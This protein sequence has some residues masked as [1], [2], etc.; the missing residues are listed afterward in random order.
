MEDQIEISTSDAPEWSIETIASDHF[1][2]NPEVADKLV[3][4]WET[5]ITSGRDKQLAG[6]FDRLLDGAMVSRPSVPGKRFEGRALVIVGESGAGKSH[7]IRYLFEKRPSL[8]QYDSEMGKMMP[9]VSVIAP[10]PC[11]L[12]QLA[13]E[14]LDAVGYPTNRNIQENV[15]WRIVKQQLK[16]RRCLILHVDE[17]QH[18]VHFSNPAEQQKLADTLKNLM[19]NPE[20]P[21]RLVLSGLP[22]LTQFRQS[23][24]QLPLRSRIH[25]VNPLQLPADG[26][27]VR[28][29]TKGILE[30]RLGFDISDLEQDEFYQRLCH[31][32]SNF[33]GR[34]GRYLQGGAE[35][36]IYAREERATREHFGEAYFQITGCTPEQNIFLAPNWHQIDPVEALSEDDEEDEPKGKTGRKKRSRK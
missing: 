17:A 22:E 26:K 35:E 11:T 3:T 8:A 15:A 2:D 5:Y 24:P 10:S 16:L 23:D 36:I 13:F 20:W 9:L 31:A 1:S 12:K 30:T 33:L 18:A 32:A 4:L 21:M 28:F 34:I 27:F 19:Q 14:I 25:L 29:M 6:Q 7:A